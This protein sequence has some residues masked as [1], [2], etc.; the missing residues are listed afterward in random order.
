VAGDV[1]KVPH[2]SFCRLSRAAG[3]ALL[4]G[5]CALTSLQTPTITPQT[6]EL[7]DAGLDQQQFRVQIHVQNPN[8]RPLPIKSVS[9]TLQV[10]GVDVG[11]GKS[12]E[13]FTVPAHGE[14]DFDM[15]VSTNFAATV[16][17]LLRQIIAGGQLPRYQF[18]GWVNPDITL[19]PPI[20]F[21]KSGQLGTP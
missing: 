20:P 17:G 8:D 16:P 5:G 19:I 14:A 9:C 21:S 1:E 10:E 7:T 6:V 4:L 18:S 3:I 12:T 13:P 11:K 2:M 15:I